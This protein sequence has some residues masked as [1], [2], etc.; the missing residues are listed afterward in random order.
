[1][2]RLLLFFTLVVWWQSTLAGLLATD[3]LGSV[4]ADGT[5]K[6]RI[7][8]EIQDNT[9][10]HIFQGAKLVAV[11]LANGIEYTIKGP[12][13]FRILASVPKSMSGTNIVEAKP[14]PAKNLPLVKISRSSTSQASMVMRNVR[15]S[16]VPVPMSPVQTA[17]LTETP[18]LHWQPVDDA[19][20]YRVTI[21]R[22]DG[23]EQWVGE[24]SVTELEVP[25][26]AKLRSG[27]SYVWQIEAMGPAYL[28]SSA[29]A[30][31]SV[32]TE[33][34]KERLKS[35]QPDADSSKS[36]Q[37]LYALQLQDAGANEDAQRY[38]RYLLKEHPDSNVL[39]ELAR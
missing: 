4:I 10:I 2:K 36:R 30:R 17:V 21:F 18:K 33:E 38:W 28:M 39:K 31:F 7:L 6:V 19:S 24:G 8:D 35:F 26:E 34:A 11:D 1:M 13:K 29:T 3:V 14:L 12:G 9:L 32:I 37:I 15:S 25:T 16:H 20:N 22:N 23:S 27:M 5:S